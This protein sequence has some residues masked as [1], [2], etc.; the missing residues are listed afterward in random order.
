[1]QGKTESVDD[2]VEAGEESGE[3]DGFGNLQITPTGNAEVFNVI[4]GDGARVAGDLLH[5]PK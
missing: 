1:L 5:E 2:A 4:R 3:V